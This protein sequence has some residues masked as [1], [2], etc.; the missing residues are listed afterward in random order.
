MNFNDRQYQ[1]F[2]QKR[3]T[4]AVLVKQQIEVLHSLNMKETESTIR[5]LEDRILTDN[6][7]VLVIGEFNRGKST[8]I[9]ALL[10]QEVLPAYSTPTTAIINEVKWGDKS[11]A[12]LYYKRPASGSLRSP[13][14]I[15]VDKI[16]KFILCCHIYL[17]RCRRL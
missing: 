9:N 4:L 10:R 14:E 12:I 8:F 15:P 16:G 6:F 2:Q 5:Q 13:Q 11:K 1:L 3:N 17:L 7:K